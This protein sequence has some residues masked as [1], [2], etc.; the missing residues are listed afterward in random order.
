[1]AHKSIQSEQEISPLAQ[2]I[3]TLKAKPK[4]QNMPAFLAMLRRNSESMLPYH[5][6]Q[7]MDGSM[8]K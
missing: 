3:L 5:S 8:Y 6:K 4:Q 7:V 2:I 1:M